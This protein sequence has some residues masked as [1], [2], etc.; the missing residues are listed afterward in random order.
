MNEGAIMSDAING[1][2]IKFSDNKQVEGEFVQM[3]QTDIMD[4]DVQDD[5]DRWDHKN[6]ELLLNFYMENIERFRNPKIKKKN[7]WVDIGNAMGRSPESC[8][9]KFRNLKLTYVRLLKT[10]KN[11]GG[12]RKWPYFETFEEIFNVNGEYQ[13]DIQQKMQE[14]DTESVAKVLLSMNTSSTHDRDVDVSG[15]STTQNDDASKKLNRKRYN[16]F[17]KISIEMRDRQRVV[18]EKLDRL[19]SIVEESNSI[20]RERNSLFEQFLEKLNR[21]Q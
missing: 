21:S 15:N 14:C 7:V 13:P 20:Q 18:E 4:S 10:K 2:E 11:K 19:I 8:D 9:K 17:K 5:E 3:N 6:I 1:S 16:E 12:Q